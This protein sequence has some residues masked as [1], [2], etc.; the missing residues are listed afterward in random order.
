MIKPTYTMAVTPSQVACARLIAKG[1]KVGHDH[2]RKPSEDIG[3]GKNQAADL[4]GALGELALITALESEGMVPTGYVFV[5]DRPPKGADFKLNGVRFSVKTAGPKSGFIFINEAQRISP[6]H[7]IDYVLPLAFDGPTKLRVFA[8]VPVADAGKWELR[9][10][11][12][13]YRSIPLR[14]LDGLASLADL[15]Q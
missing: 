10:G 4:V 6:D 2:T 13:P 8:P 12:S 9:E 1:R 11:H 15:P 14:N 5:A 7:E 3:A